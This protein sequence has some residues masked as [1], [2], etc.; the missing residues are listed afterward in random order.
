MQE[1]RLAFKRHFLDE[2][3]A[4]SSRHSKAKHQSK[5]NRKINH[6]VMISALSSFD[7]CDDDK[8]IDSKSGVKNTMPVKSAQPTYPEGVSIKLLPM[9]KI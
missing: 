4:N 6:D 5:S 2:N 7:G 1:Q 3:L 9:D 8:R